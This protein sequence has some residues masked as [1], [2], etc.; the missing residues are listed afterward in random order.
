MDDLPPELDL[1]T[2]QKTIDVAQVFVLEIEANAKKLAGEGASETKVLAL[3][4]ALLSAIIGVS[5]KQIHPEIED[6]VCSGHNLRKK[7]ERARD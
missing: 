2:I 4:I 3:Y 1:V 7:H 6:I 5:N